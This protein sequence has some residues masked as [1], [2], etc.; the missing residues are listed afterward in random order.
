M[1]KI[2]TLLFF[3]FLC[4]N[5][6]GQKGTPTFNGDKEPMPVDNTD[7]STMQLPLALKP[8]LTL[9]PQ[10][11][12]AFSSAMTFIP[13]EIE[14][15]G[16]SAT[17]MLLNGTDVK[18]RGNLFPNG[19]ID[20]YSFQA[21]A[22]DKV[23]AAIMTSFSSGSSTDSQIT[24]LAS[25]GTT[26]IEFDD[27]N[28]TFAGLSSSI[29]GATIPTTGTY[30][31][32]V[33]DFTAGTA[34]E[35]S[36]DLY[37]KVQSGSPTPEVEGNDTPAAANVLPNSGWVSGAR[38]T[39]ASTEQD[40]YSV[41]LNAGETLFMSLDLDPERD[42]TVW[43]GRLGIALFGDAG[44]QIL[45]IDDAGTGDVLPNPNKPSEAL[46]F[47]VKTTGTYFVFVDAASAAVGGPTA[48]YELSVSK[49]DAPTGYT[50]YT[51]TDVPK[52]IGP[53]TGVVSSTLNIPD[54]KTIK[55]IQVNVVLNHALMQDI[56]AILTSPEGNKIAL[57]TD[58]GSPSTG[59]QT[60]MDANFGDFNALPPSFTVL[61]GV[62]LMPELGSK[63]DQLR[64]MKS[65]GVWTLD[66]FD[67]T[68]GANGGTLTSWSIDIL[69][70][71]LSTQ[72]AAYSSIFNAD[73]EVDD[74][75][76]T[77]S[78]T[79]DQWA[80]GLPA[81]VATSA[82]NPVAAFN[83]ANS[84]VNCFKTNLTGTYAASSIQELKSPA[85]DLTAVTAN[86]VILS[87]AMKYQIESASFDHLR[88]IVREVGVPTN[89]KEV[90]VWLGATQTVQAGNPAINVPMSSG[91]GTYY[92]DVSEFKG[93]IIE[94]VFHLDTDTTIQ[95][96]GV[97][98][99]DVSVKVSETTPDPPTVTPPSSLIVCSP[100]TLT[101]T[102]TCAT[103]T[104][105][106]S[107][108]GATGSTLTLSAVGTY[109]ITA[110]CSN[111][112]YSSTASSPVSLEIK[113]LPAAPT[114][115]TVNNTSICLG[116]S[117]SLSA[118]CGAPDAPIFP[119][120]PSGNISQQT[121]ALHGG[122]SANSPNDAGVI[123]Y[124]EASG[125]TAIGMGSPLNHAPTANTTYYAA[126]VDGGCESAR[127]AT[128]A[129]TVLTP[130]SIPTNTANQT[131]CIGTTASLSAT[132][133]T[134]LV[135]WFDASG[136]NLLA[137]GSPFLTP[138]LSTDTD[139][140]VRCDD[141]TCPSP[142]VTV[143]VLMLSGID[144]GTGVDGAY[145]ATSNTTLAG[146][147]YNFTNFNIDAGVTVTVTGTQPLYIKATGAVT[148]NG[149]LLAKGSDGTNGVTFSS[150]GLGGNGIAGGAN[151]GNG[152]FSSSLGPLDGFDGVGLGGIG[153]KGK[154]WS[155]GGGAGY[156][157]IGASSGN[158][159]GGFGGA[160]Y[161]NANISGS[162]A[163]SG[164][165]GGSGGYDC[166]AGGGG[167]GGGFVRISAQTSINIGA[168]G[169]INTNGGNGGT[170]GTGNCGGGGGGSG[171]SLWL[172][173]PSFT[174]NGSLLALGGT[175]GAST[176]N[177]APYYGTGADGSVGR[178]RLDYNG[179]LV[180]SGTAQP[181]VGATNTIISA[182]VSPP[183]GTSNPTIC[184]NTT[185]S[186]SATCAAGT[187][188][189]Y[190]AGG[191]TLQGT[192]SPFVTPNLTSN[193]TYKVRCEAS[194]NSTFVDV[195]VSINPVTAP[196]VTPPSQLIVCS[197][198]TLTLTA[199]C[200]TGNVVWSDNSTGTSLTLNTV[201][202]YAITAKCTLNGCDS[203][204][205]SAMSL[206]I[207]A[208][209][210]APSISAPSQLVVCSPTTLTLTATCTT[211]NV[212]WS[213][214]STG[215]S[216][217]LSAVGT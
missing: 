42:G 147:T 43:N 138:T 204:Q 133:A 186:L 137:T 198:S 87:W 99:D 84:G 22:G 168:T 1:K 83:N 60:Q 192:G 194:C 134:G 112:V 175:G 203:D 143:S 162:E 86:V 66:L 47:T 35:R 178:I 38:N 24:L 4:I 117:V 179:S 167:A 102:A 164:G 177:Y 81:T 74:N 156:A 155:G 57:F 62:A 13:K 130:P 187:I 93:K 199:T 169:V 197:P 139:Y 171:G 103:G 159:A 39:A 152:I 210:N 104:V 70:D 120:Q 7:V 148:I 94:I 68:A 101:L 174:Q 31:I 212:L 129:V 65:N 149:T 154:A 118:S 12:T 6:F 45:V 122:L 211:G 109:S 91:W 40:W 182:V 107:Q 165:G 56:D 183:T 172:A 180:G 214:N 72:S 25:D 55:D 141:G 29:A 50:T 36:Y 188:N 23:Y 69:E 53:G 14:P 8:N 77:H 58:I 61:K 185:A 27:D 205:S 33:N 113:A 85:I 100:S 124:T 19:D 111:N 30:F 202:T 48:T 76:F 5:I 208:K 189:W 200:T 216:L 115:V 16:T 34:S 21:T 54:A 213:D 140:K 26:V 145:S 80:R 126:C 105:T 119:T 79:G 106:W 96:G 10:T 52:T 158:S 67:D 95:L 184:N 206:E 17:A 90:F 217:T 146:G 166:G 51:S 132:C 108:G 196:T 97:A 44:N 116:S 151:G 89:S 121:G 9:F 135:K 64:G 163:G 78:G 173:S 181:T 82:A 46:F 2:S 32:K 71:P 73:F 49:L 136:T 75:G 92:V 127:V 170:D 160:I 131:I 207:K 37:L 125:G 157:A 59:G 144:A 28:G 209:P 191:T 193:T 18:I 123:W 98:V 142:F 201:G 128:S 110:T 88:V 41:T 114:G 63:F 190:D 15:N 20:F 11:V 150:A 3:L 161:G 195:T 215:T 176:V 153:N